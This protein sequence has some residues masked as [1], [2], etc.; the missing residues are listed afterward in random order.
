MVDVMLRAQSTG[1]PSHRPTRNPVLTGPRVPRRPW[2]A[3]P[4]NAAINAPIVLEVPTT[5]AVVMDLLVRRDDRDGYLNACRLIQD[6]V[7]VSLGG[8][9][10]VATVEKVSLHC[11]DHGG[12]IVFPHA[13]ITVTGAGPAHRYAARAALVDRTFQS[14]LMEH[15]ADVPGGIV[16]CEESPH[17]WELATMLHEISQYDDA[18]KLQGAPRC[19]ETVV[20][21]LYPAEWDPGWYTRAEPPQRH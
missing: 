3:L 21:A 20:E 15:F 12:Q 11:G 2:G 9:R 4:E 16:R 5:V 6:A 7:E 19:P 17:G 10:A 8:L 13:V 14:C 18:P 1:T